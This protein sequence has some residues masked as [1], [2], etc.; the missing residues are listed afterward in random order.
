M[1]PTTSVDENCIVFEFQTDGNYYVDLRLT[2]LALKLK[3]VRGRGY[4]TYNTKEVKKGAQRRDK[5]IRGR[6]GGRGSSSS[7]YSCE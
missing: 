4:E 6:D 1:Y 3:L 2:Y 7:R 5:S